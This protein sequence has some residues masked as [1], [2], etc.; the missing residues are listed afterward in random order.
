MSNLF[1]GRLVRLRA[2]EVNDWENLLK[3]GAD[4]D[5]AWLLDHIWFPSSQEQ[6]QTFVEEQAKRHSQD[7]TFQFQIERLDGEFVGT[8]NTHTVDKRCGTFRYGIA[9]LPPHRRAGVATEAVRLVLRYYFRE[10]RYQKV[11]AEMWSFNTSSIRLHEHLGFRLEGQLRRMNYT[12]GEY[13]DE[14]IYGLTCEEF[15]ASGWDGLR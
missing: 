15:E 12:G 10:R 3:W 14:L 6:L 2:T 9:V 5:S 13:H 8:L 1:Q 7:D 4:T 11:N